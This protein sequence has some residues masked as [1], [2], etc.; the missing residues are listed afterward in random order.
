MRLDF[1]VACGQKEDLQQHH[2]FPRAMGG[3]DEECNLITLCTNCHGKIHGIKWTHNHSELIKL[4]HAKN[5]EKIVAKRKE[6]YEADAERMVSV[7]TGNPVKTRT[8][9]A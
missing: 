2:L 1:C 7:I 6:R 8:S 3:S 4:G 5:R 9:D